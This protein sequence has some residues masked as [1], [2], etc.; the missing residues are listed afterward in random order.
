MRLQRLNISCNKLHRIEGRN[1]ST[2]L[3]LVAMT[4][5]FAGLGSSTAVAQDRSTL[6]SPDTY[7]F[8]KAQLPVSGSIVAVYSADSNPF[9]ALVGKRRVRNKLPKRQD[10][11]VQRYVVSNGN[12]EFLFHGAEG[13]A[14]IQF[15][16]GR[17]DQRIEC[18]IDSE[19]EAAEIHSLVV[20]RAPRGDIIYKDVSGHTL[21]RIASYG[22]ATVWWP[23]ESEALAA[24]RSFSDRITLAL[25]LAD[26]RTVLRRATRAT[27]IL[28]ALTGAPIEFDTGL[29]GPAVPAATTNIALAAARTAPSELA[30]STLTS[31]TSEYGDDVVATIASVPKVDTQLGSEADADVDAGQTLQTTQPLSPKSAVL[32]DTIVMTSKGMASVASDPTGA[33]VIGTRLK[34]VHFVEA[35]SP[36]MLLENQEFEVRYTP[37]LGLKGRPTSAQVEQFLEEN[38]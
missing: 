2:M 9:N 30:V 1:I 26:E 18:Q 5:F 16:C 8:P 21:L 27:A 3:V 36:S 17:K 15:L 6:S 4:V 23:G 31:R 22:G 12:R 32:A 24:S 38:L 35:D 11:R 7:T 13:Q 10:E 34:S 28:S 33:R 37:A 29:F 19:Q 20:T 25:P 14:R